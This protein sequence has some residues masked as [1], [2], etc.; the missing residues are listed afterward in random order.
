VVVDVEAGD[1]DVAPLAASRP[2]CS[3][4]AEEESGT[5]TQTAAEATARRTGPL[6]IPLGLVV[7]HNMSGTGHA[8]SQTSTCTQ[9]GR[10]LNLTQLFVTTGRIRSPCQRPVADGS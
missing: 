4:F 9:S 7:A 1:P 6:R 2:G 10:A 5:A 3:A 8:R